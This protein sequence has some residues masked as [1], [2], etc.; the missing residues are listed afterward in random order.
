MTR[1]ITVVAIG[2]LS[3][4]LIVGT[5]GIP[6]IASGRPANQIPVAHLPG[7]GGSLQTPTG[8]AWQEVEQVTVPLSSAP[9]GLPNAAAVST[10]AV[11]VEA[12][13][14]EST[15]YVRMRWKDP[16]KN[17]TPEGPH[18]FADAVAMQI[19]VA[20]DSHPAI[21]LGGR[22]N[23]VNVWYWNAETGTQ[24]IL[25]GGPGT[26]TV[27]GSGIR[28]KAVHR[29]DGWTVV[30]ARDLTVPGENRTQIRMEHDLDVAFAV[31]NGAN[32]E[33]S[34][35]HAVSNWFHYPLGPQPSGPPYQSL[36]WT[37]AG[38]AI[39]VIVVVTLLAVRRAE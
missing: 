13:R 5:I 16:T 34:G 15:L 21:A 12:A 1:R 30:L 22:Q 27:I 11:R 6:S 14:T 25:A 29:D 19:P 9:S 18:G 2:L 33:R 31:W 23:P 7:E 36:L 38:I 37:I 39:A 26:I 35:R 8:S 17:A 10:D 28:A 24:E 20:T 32:E 4:S 3:V